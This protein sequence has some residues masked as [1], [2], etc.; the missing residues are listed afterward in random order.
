MI[1]SVKEEL[2]GK[3]NIPTTQYPTIIQDLVCVCV[4]QMRKMH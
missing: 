1:T 2:R 4:V 3:H